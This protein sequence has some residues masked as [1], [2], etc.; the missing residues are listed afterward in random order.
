M[1]KKTIEVGFLEWEGV[2]EKAWLSLTSGLELTRSTLKQCD[3]YTSIIC[4]L[5]SNRKQLDCLVIFRN[6]SEPSGG[7]C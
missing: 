1:R 5:Y 7:G 4:V 2:R 6:A 3:T